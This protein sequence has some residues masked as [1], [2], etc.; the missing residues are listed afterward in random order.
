MSQI[1]KNDSRAK[2]KAI[3][4][5]LIE[6]I[7]EVPDAELE[8]ELTQDGVDIKK[9]ANSMRSG[10][11][12]LIIQERRKT[13]AKARAGMLVHSVSKSDKRQRPNLESIKRSLAD[14]FQAK[15]SLAVAFRQG[16]SQ[17]ETDWYS[18]WEDLVELGEISEISDEH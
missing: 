13:L 9:I 7:Y 14:L 10:A 11:L 4:Q 12:D 5:A 16:R 6:D 18:L 8:K 1:P 3:E 17:S 15:P 2:I